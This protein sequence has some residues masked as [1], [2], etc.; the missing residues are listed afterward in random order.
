MLITYHNKEV[1]WKSIS[2]FRALQRIAQFWLNS[3]VSRGRLDFND[4][5]LF[6]RN[7]PNLA[8][9]KR[10]HNLKSNIICSPTELRPNSRE[11][12]TRNWCQRIKC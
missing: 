7:A 3:F 10:L 9:S 2:M 11:E 6:F 8:N 1:I 4:N 5:R 12:M